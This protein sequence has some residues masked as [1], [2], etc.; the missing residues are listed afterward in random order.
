MC[1]LNVGGREAITLLSNISQEF[2][3]THVGLNMLFAKLNKFN[4]N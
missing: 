1:A 3:I 4:L 2:F